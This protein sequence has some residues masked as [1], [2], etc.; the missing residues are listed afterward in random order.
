MKNS[1]AEVIDNQQIIDNEIL[2]LFSEFY[3]VRKVSEILKIS[4]RQVNKV[5]VK[6]KIQGIKRKPKLKNFNVTFFE[7]IDTQEKAYFAGLIHADG[8]VFFKD[9]KK[10][11]T[12][13]L[14][15]ND[16]DILEKLAFC[17]N[18]PQTRIQHVPSRNNGKAQ[19][20]ITIGGEFA[21]Y[22]K[23]IKN[24]NYI[25]NIPLDLRRHFIRGVF[26]GD[27]S[28]YTHTTKGNLYYYAGFI[29]DTQMIKFIDSHLPIK[30]QQV[31]STNSKG[32]SRIEYF[33]K[34]QMLKLFDYFYLDATV[35]LQRKYKKFLDMKFH[36]NISTT[37]RKASLM[38]DDDIV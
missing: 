28:I 4:Y 21:T 23:D 37:T 3:S 17:L 11:F 12:I 15:E 14:Q 30:A 18:I 27:G 32:I 2:T 19:K 24:P 38:R 20:R 10:I 5:L 36:Y 7:T 25:D 26:D 33:A 31:K 22:L 34:E 13:S 9:R 35:F 6:H 1:N 8:C 16:V 29:G